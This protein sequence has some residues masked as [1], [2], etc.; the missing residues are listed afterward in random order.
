MDPGILSY[1]WALDHSVSARI[2]VMCSITLVNGAV[3]AL[4]PVVP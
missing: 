2:A 4:G 3:E 1:N